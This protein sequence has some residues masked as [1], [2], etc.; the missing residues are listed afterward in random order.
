MYINIKTPHRCSKC[1]HE[2]D[3]DVFFRN[4][5][6]IKKCRIC[7]HER[8]I[9]TITTSSTMNAKYIEYVYTKPEIEEF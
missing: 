5:D 8:I 9:S 4:N 7:G 6:Q 2:G 1:K 3:P